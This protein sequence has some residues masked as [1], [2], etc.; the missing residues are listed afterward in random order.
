MSK[1]FKSKTYNCITV[2]TQSKEIKA[3]H[4][5]DLDDILKKYGQLQDFHSGNM[6]CHVCYHEISS[7]N[8][9]SMKLVNEK[10]VFACNKI[11][12]YDKIV[13]TIHKS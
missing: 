2:S 6:K 7:T 12:C 3:V 11:S 1:L 5:A 4:I 10:F 8:V 9:G 13:K